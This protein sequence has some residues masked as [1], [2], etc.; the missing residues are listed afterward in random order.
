MTRILER[1]LASNQCN[2][3]C[4]RCSQRKPY[5][6]SGILSPT[7]V[8]IIVASVGQ[9]RKLYKIVSI[10]IK[11]GRYG[12]ANDGEKKPAPSRQRKE[13]HKYLYSVCMTG[14]ITDSAKTDRPKVCH[15]TAR[16][17]D[18]T[19]GQRALC[20]KQKEEPC[21]RRPGPRLGGRGA[22]KSRSY[23]IRIQPEHCP[24][25]QNTVP[26]NRSP[27]GVILPSPG[28]PFVH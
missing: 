13:P 10:A 24:F 5:H 19:G 28:C 26:R 14:P 8:E 12:Q 3:R 18:G 25:R 15:H 11:N 2:E 20:A 22:K 23:C 27:L 17:D 9:F 1:T 21:C 7:T 16:R 4:C 6:I